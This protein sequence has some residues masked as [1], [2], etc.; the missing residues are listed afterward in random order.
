M[1]RYLQ[2]GKANLKLSLLP[3]LLLSTLL[4]FLSPLVMGVENLDASRTA[5]VL[6]MFIALLGIILITPVLLPEQN[7]DIRDLVEAK[8]TSMTAVVLIRLL[9][10]IV[11][12][13]FLIGGYV[14]FLSFNHCSFPEFKFYLGTLAEALFLGG[15]GFCTYSIF[16]QIAIAYMLP[17][18]YYIV[19]ISPGRKLLKDFYLFSMRFGSYQEKIYLFVSGLVLICIGI[20]YPYLVKRILPKLIRRKK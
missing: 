18:V 6:E 20:G 7:K 11:S 8:Y 13:A 17:L 15:I 5:A 2:I 10:A 3:H 9:E 1:V 16:D 4:L 12:L 19:S 14:I